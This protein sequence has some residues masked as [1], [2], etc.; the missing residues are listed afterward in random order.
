MNRSI[1]TREP[2][3]SSASGTDS[4]EKVTI[5]IEDEAIVQILDQISETEEFT[6]KEFVQKLLKLLLVSKEGQQLKQFAD[7]RNRT[8]LA[9]LTSWMNL[10][11]SNLPWDEIR[12]LACQSQRYPEQM[13]VFLILE[14]LRAYKRK[15]DSAQD[16][17]GNSLII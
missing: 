15:L 16:T 10:L 4:R 11:Q 6:R 5:R 12:E 9:E 8:V 3:D 17:E 1:R 14:G 13:I 7:H 2:A